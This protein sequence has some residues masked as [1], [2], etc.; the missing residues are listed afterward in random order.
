MEP[1]LSSPPPAPPKRTTTKRR[2]SGQ[3]RRAVRGFARPCHPALRIPIASVAAYYVKHGKYCHKPRGMLRPTSNAGQ[4]AEDRIN[5]MLMYNAN[6]LVR[7]PAMP[8]TGLW[9]FFA[10]LQRQSEPCREY[11]GCQYALHRYHQRTIVN[12]FLQIQRRRDDFIPLFS[13]APRNA[14]SAAPIPPALL[15]RGHLSHQHAALF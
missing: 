7:L 12:M 2:L 14:I 1:G 3:L 9:Y 8:I 6:S 15:R 11:S 4:Y 5:A 10:M 13:S